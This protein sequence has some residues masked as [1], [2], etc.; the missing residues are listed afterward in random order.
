MELLDE[1]DEDSVC[2][3]VVELEKLEELVKSD[4]GSMYSELDEL[5]DSFDDIGMDCNDEENISSAEVDMNN[6][7]VSNDI[8]NESDCFDDVL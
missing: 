3:D 6:V 4:D 8:G 1:L 7:D 2:E 5:V